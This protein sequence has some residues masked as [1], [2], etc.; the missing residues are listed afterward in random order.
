MLM[1]YT[2]SF[3]TYDIYKQT[4][5][6]THTRL[7]YELRYFVFM[8][9]FVYV[10]WGMQ[11]NPSDEYAVSASLYLEMRNTRDVIKKKKLFISLFFVFRVFSLSYIVISSFNSAFPDLAY[12]YPVFNENE[13][14]IYERV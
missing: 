11:R 4:N 5:T 9:V 6:H 7:W 13:E 2:M 1:Q 8:S 14:M 10:W 12:T 3:Q